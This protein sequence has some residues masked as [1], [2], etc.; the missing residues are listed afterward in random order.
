MKTK[1]KNQAVTKNSHE[2]YIKEK[3]PIAFC[4]DRLTLQNLAFKNTQ[5]VLTESELQE[6]THIISSE[7]EIRSIISDWIIWTM[8]QITDKKSVLLRRKLLNLIHNQYEN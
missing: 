5:K 8:K 7:T 6:L 2:K 3:Y 1:F 4:F